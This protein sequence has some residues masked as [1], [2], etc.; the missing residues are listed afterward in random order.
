M[1]SKIVTGSE[2]FSEV[3]MKLPSN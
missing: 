3:G 1:F 2:S